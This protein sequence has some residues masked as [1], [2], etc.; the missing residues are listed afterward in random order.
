M[1]RKLICALLVL[2]VA[3]SVLAG[4]GSQRPDQGENDVEAT[5]TVPK[6]DIDLSAFSLSTTTW[7]SP[8]GLTVNLTAVPSVHEEGQSAA[9]LV[10]LNGVEEAS[11]PCEWNGSDYTASVDLNAADGYNYYVVVTT[12]E[13]AQAEIPVNTPDNLYDATLINLATALNAYCDVTVDTS[14]Y[15]DNVLTIEGGM[16]QVQTPRISS[17]GQSVTC[18]S[19]SLVLTFNGESVSSQP[20]NLTEAELPGSYMQELSSLTFSIPT[21]VEGQTLELRMDATL[22]DG[23]QLT[24]PGGSWTFSGGTLMSTVG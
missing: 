10:R 14:S 7:S 18:T 16:A 21:M 12:A 2:T 17:D 9:F 22:S 24:A 11:V 3:V 23:Q 1:K 6:A 13:G 4:C 20:L 8:N 15:A 19:A 5:L